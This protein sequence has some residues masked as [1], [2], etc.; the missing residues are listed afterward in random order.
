MDLLKVLSIENEW[1][2]HFVILSQYKFIF[3]GTIERR[4]ISFQQD[5]R[6]EAVIVMRAVS[7]IREQ[8]SLA[9]NSVNL[10]EKMMTLKADWIE[11]LQKHG[12][13]GIRD[14]ILKSIC[15]DV[16]GMYPVKL[17]IALAICSGNEISNIKSTDQ[18]DLHHRGQSHILLIG[19]PGLAKSK[20]LL[21]AVQ[22]APRAVHTTGMGC[23]SAGLT[24]AAVKEDGEWVLEAG[25]LVLADGGIC[26]IDEFN[27]MRESDKSSIHEAMEQQTISMA[28]AGIVCKLN[29][30]C[31]I[32][33]AANPKNL[34]AMSEADGTSSINIGIASPLLS[35]FD[36]VFILR[37]ERI[38]EW[39][40][41]I[42][43]HLLAQ[44]MT[45]FQGFSVDKNSELWSQQK[46]QSHFDAIS[47]IHP[48]MT[49][50]ASELLRAYY[51][52]CRLDPE[53]EYS[54][55][56]IRLLDSLNRLAEAHARLVFRDEITVVDAIV[57][58]RL[59]ESTF[60]FG[61]FVKP[62]DVIKEE[63]PLGPDEDE[64]HHILNIFDMDSKKNQRPIDQNPSPSLAS[65]SSASPSKKSPE[66]QPERSQIPTKIHKDIEK[67]TTD[68]AK[69]Q[70]VNLVKTQ[71]PRLIPSISNQSS[72]VQPTIDM[73]LDEIDDILSFGMSHHVYLNLVYAF[74]S[75]KN[76]FFHHLM[77]K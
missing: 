12:E 42:A 75:L 36:L 56:T 66:N 16:Y 29:T 46:L 69:V 55:T 68:Q 70:S 52:K 3:S 54:R 57:T 67:S 44:A 77:Q 27:M 21:S 20:L 71:P 7:L 32:I 9:I 61:H 43:D 65:T 19:D 60:G 49:P 28:K 76:T 14:L 62:Y 74:Y 39:D 24:A 58:I 41:A 45:G 26:C 13:L 2:E 63:L 11:Q 48:K 40:D 72:N 31:A 34:S 4:W 10:S 50:L 18:D 23:S 5:G 59:M 37:D 25:A 17:A 51:R 1:R 38:P 47:R 73:D 53:R 8:N 33:A 15:P 6:C 64:I 30:R 22:I 35:R